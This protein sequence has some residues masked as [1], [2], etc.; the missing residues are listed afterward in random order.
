MVLDSAAV[1]FLTLLGLGIIALTVSVFLNALVDRRMDLARRQM[2][3]ERDQ[4][5]EQ[6]QRKEPFWIRFGEPIKRSIQSMAWTLAG[7]GLLNFFSYGLF[8]AAEKFAAQKAGSLPASIADEIQKLSVWVKQGSDILLRIVFVAVTGI[9]V[10][11]FLQGGIRGLV[12]GS[13]ATNLRSMHPRSRIR[14]ETLLT[15][16]GNVINIGVLIFCLMIILQ[17]VGVSVAPLLAT[18]GVASV[19]VGFGAQSLV[20][21]VL[22]GFFILFEDQ[23]AVGDVITIDARTGTVESLT[24]RCTRLRMSDGTLVV[25]PNGEIKKIENSTSGYSQIDFRIAILYGPQLDRALDL[26]T[27]QIQLLAR[28]YSSEIMATPEILGVESVND[29]RIVL[30]ARIKTKPGKQFALERELNHRMMRKFLET[31]IELP[32]NA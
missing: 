8:Q 13:N 29:S 7:L 25:I 14:T 18:A 16:S 19:A 9:W 3:N 24:L 5:G 27:E 4:L 30:R 32:G 17:M 20:R 12:H 21:D 6:E 1:P 22:T 10:A 31:K 28:E 2:D 15:T 23:F 11:R 26:L